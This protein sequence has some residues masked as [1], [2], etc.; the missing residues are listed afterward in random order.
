MS[1]EDKCPWQEATEDADEGGCIDLRL[2]VRS[3]ADVV[4]AIPYLMGFHPRDSLVLVCT[5]AEDAR[6]IAFTSRVDLPPPD[7]VPAMAQHLAG[8]VADNGCDEVLIVVIGGGIL[9]DQPPRSDVVAAMSEACASVGVGVWTSV[10]VSELRAKA[11]WRRYGACGGGGSLPDPATS[12]VAAAAVAAGQ[13]TYAD[14]SDLERLVAPADPEA[15]R[16]RSALL[17]A[18]CEQLDD[19]GEFAGGYASMETVRAW[20]ERAASDHFCLGDDDVVELCLALCDPIVRDAGFG[21]A[22]GPYA[23]AAE[24]LWT[25][26]V[27]QSPDP[28]AAEA[29]V[30]L[31]HCAL[32]RGNGALAG[33]ALERAQQAWPTH[34][35]SVMFQSALDSG[36]GPDELRAWFEEG[37]KHAHAVLRQRG[38]L[39]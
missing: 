3:P 11:P 14:R 33:I 18:Q 5:R 12:P 21:F 27:Q 17:D 1:N 25:A 6:R 10:W 2:R 4:A 38:E 39:C 35:L 34:R 15:L 23:A 8:I 37:V 7:N 26:L 36:L 29:A 13:V 20:V 28:D 24:R 22:S 19:C 31:A 16:R 30:L 32:L 9:T